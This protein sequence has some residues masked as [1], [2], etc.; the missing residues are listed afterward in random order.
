M[1]VYNRQM[2]TV[3]AASNNSILSVYDLGI[4]ELNQA[5]N[6]TALH[7]AV[8]WL[9]N[10]TA[11]GLPAVS[12]IN[13]W[14]WLAP[15]GTYSS[16]W[17]ANVY[18]TLQSLLAFILWEFCTNNNENPAVVP[19]QNGEQPNLPAAFQ[20]IASISQPYPRF[21]LNRVTFIIYLILESLALILCWSVIVWQCISCHH[22]PEI[23]SYPLVDFASKLQ[24]KPTLDGGNALSLRSV[25]LP[26]SDDK[27]IRHALTRLE[28]IVVSNN[29][30]T[31][32]SGTAALPDSDNDQRLEGTPLGSPAHSIYHS[33]TQSQRSSSVGRGENESH[34]EHQTDS[35]FRRP[36]SEAPSESENRI[37]P[38]NQS[39]HDTSALVDVPT[40]TDVSPDATVTAASSH[41]TQL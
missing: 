15:S 18:T 4:P 5:I 1:A 9:L 11:S 39:N 35:E 17:E 31:D 7:L 3:C 33:L 32:G 24:E 38:D 2:T 16:L 25:I 13:F 40:D 34:F 10:Y 41:T 8:G 19:E 30:Q 29:G 26:A 20:T 27:A 22:H 37:I 21:V 6:I 36:Q 14:F 12:S 28:M 23:S